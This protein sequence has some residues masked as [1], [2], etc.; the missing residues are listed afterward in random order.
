MTRAPPV[1]EPGSV[2]TRD[3]TIASA[4]S[5]SWCGTKNCPGAYTS[6]ECNSAPSSHPSARPR[7]PRKRASTG[8]SVLFHCRLSIF[9]RLVGI[10]QVSR[11]PGSTSVCSPR[12]YRAGRPN[13]HSSLACACDTGS[14]SRPS[15]RT[16]M[17]SPSAGAVRCALNEPDAIT[18]PRATARRSPATVVTVVPPSGQEAKNQR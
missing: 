15:P 18:S 2:T 12:P 17:C 7:S 11:T 5:E 10:S 16:S 3:P 6:I 9:T 8:S 4:F 13:P 1:N 14:T